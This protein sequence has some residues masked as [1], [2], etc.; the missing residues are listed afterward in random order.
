[1][2]RFGGG[3]RRPFPLEGEEGWGVEPVP[4]RRG[5]PLKESN[6]GMLAKARKETAPGLD[7]IMGAVRTRLWLDDGVEK[8]DGVLR[9]FWVEDLGPTVGHFARS[10]RGKVSRRTRVRDW[11]DMIGRA[12]KRRP[13]D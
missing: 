4:S 12:M 8:Q 11:G 2:W 9:S 5:N 1:V 6:K 7:A 10:A 13:L 3:S